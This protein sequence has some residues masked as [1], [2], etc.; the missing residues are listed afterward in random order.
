MRSA[1]QLQHCAHRN[2]V[3]YVQAWEEQDHLFIQTELCECGSLAEQLE[4]QPDE[5]HFPEVKV[6]TFLLDIA[7][8]S[9]RRAGFTPARPR[10]LNKKDYRARGPLQ[11][12][13]NPLPRPPAFDPAS[14][15][16]LVLPQQGLKCVHELDMVHMDLKPGNIFLA[17]DGTL[18]IGDFGLAIQSGRWTVDEGQ[19]GDNAYMAPELLR[20]ELGEV[21]CAADIFSLGILM[22]EVASGLDMPH[23]GEVWLSL[24]NGEGSKL[25]LLPANGIYSQEL[26]SIIWSC[27][28][29]LPSDRATAADICSE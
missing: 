8:V 29:P 12:T 6:W 22:L 1:R 27:L 4:R 28:E 17:A 11:S 3:Q 14:C 10:R 5:Y 16:W 18:K 25:G 15:P 20:P 13:T 2:I 26:Q 24:R 19:E 21:T 9:C 7:R 23:N